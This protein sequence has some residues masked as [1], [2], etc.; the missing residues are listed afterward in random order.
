MHVSRDSNSNQRWM[1]FVVGE[2]ASWFGQMIIA[3]ENLL[4]LQ[5][6]KTW[7]YAGISHKMV[8]YPKPTISLEKYPKAVKIMGPNLAHNTH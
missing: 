8:V 5:L 1:N 3:Q 4:G 7:N 6:K 2:R